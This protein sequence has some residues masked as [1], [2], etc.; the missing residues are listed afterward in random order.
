VEAGIDR[1]ESAA[2]REHRYSSGKGI[3]AVLGK[4]SATNIGFR[5]KL[6]FAA[7]KLR[8]YMDAGEYQHVF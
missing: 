1:Q 7:D 5:A 3:Q 4:D 2:L 6:W 8:N